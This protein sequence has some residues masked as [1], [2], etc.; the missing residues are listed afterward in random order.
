[1]AVP[2]MAGPMMAVLGFALSDVALWSQQVTA[3]Q[4]FRF[5]RVTITSLVQ[6]VARVRIAVGDGVVHEGFAADFA[7]PKWFRKDPARSVDDDVAELADSAHRAAA[8]WLRAAGDGATSAFDAWRSAY[9]EQVA[10]AEFDDALVAGFGVA[11]IERAVVDAVCRAAHLPFHRALREGALGFAPSAIDPPL[12]DGWL[13]PAEPA[14]SIALR[15]TVGL[16]DPLTD[17]DIDPASPD[18]GLPRSLAA[19][20]ARYGLDHFKIKLA[21]D[22]AADRARLLAIARVLREAGVVRPLCTLDGNEGFASLESVAELLE[23]TARE[24]DGAWLLAGLAFVEQPLPRFATFDPSRHAAWRRVLRFAPLALDEADVRPGALRAA[25][26]FGYRGVSAKSC[27]GLFRALTNAVLC[28]TSPELFVCGEDLTTLPALALQQDLALLATLGIAHAERNGH[29][30][31]RPLAHLTP[32]ERAAALA[33]HPALYE[34]LADGGAALGIRSGRL[35]LASL[36]TEGLGGAVVV[37]PEART[38][39][40]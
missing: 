6:L 34:E 2:M 22:V 14:P 7:A 18:D 38:R 19:A 28:A 26:P 11:L 4:P 36:L 16:V 20:V 9:R 1:M 40:R 25:R 8:A 30:F 27:K 23:R 39:L 24:S 29:H 31:F 5:G 21:G 32:A 13:P 3:R 35:A 10:A 33:A 12:D 37:E 17:A 15:H